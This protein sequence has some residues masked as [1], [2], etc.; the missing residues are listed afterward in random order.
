MTES[1]KYALLV[2]INYR[3]SDCELS[4]CINDV[5]GMKQFLINHA[6]Y[7]EDNIIVLTEDENSKHQPT[8]ENIIK[9]LY[10]LIFKAND[11]NT[12]EI[13]FHYSGHG[14]YQRDRDGDEDD[15]RDE[16]I[17]PLDYNKSGDISDDLLRSM[18]K[19]VPQSCQVKCIFDC[20]H[21]GTILDLKYQYRRGDH[22]NVEN[23]ASRL[24]ANIIMI[25]GCRDNQTSAD[26]YDVNQDD[27]WSGAMTSSFLKVMSDHDYEI[28]WKNLLLDMR[29][30]LRDN[31]YTQVP[32]ICSSFKLEPDNFFFQ[33]LKK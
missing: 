32:Q 19:K 7:S 20:C 4:G 25:S 15:G 2:G 14:S 26:A 31:E 5:Q 24:P 29:S 21:S 16:V 1:N 33:S 27:K 6:G 23:Q 18:F 8:K 9:K 13:W 3:G 22:F 28:S 30:F 17:V 11:A 10:N 12:S